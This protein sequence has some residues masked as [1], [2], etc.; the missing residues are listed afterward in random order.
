MLSRTC[1]SAA[2]HCLYLPKSSGGLHLSSL[3]TIFKKTECGLAASQMSSQDSTVRL[4][5]SR[6]T[7]AERSA[8]RITFKPY[9]EVVEVMQEDPGASRP[10]LT[11][12]VKRRVTTADNKEQLENCRKLVVQGNLSRLFDDQ[13]SRTWSQAVWNLLERV[14]KFTLN[15][16]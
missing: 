8:K 11:R 15:A 12:A 7:T 3:S 1:R 14:M 2:T 4:I 6:K 13:A 16:A 10:Q 9:Q 5:A